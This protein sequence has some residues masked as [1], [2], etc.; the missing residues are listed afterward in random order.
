MN[1]LLDSTDPASTPPASFKEAL[2]GE[3][4]KFS[5]EEELAKGKWESDLYIK[6]L[7]T[8]MDQLTADYTRLDADYKA[9]ASLEEMI[10]K[11]GLPKTPASSDPPPANQSQPT[12]DQS[13]LKN[14]ISQSLQETREQEKQQTNFNMVKTKL[15]ERYGN[16]YQSKLTE[17]MQE[18]GLNATAVD[19]LAHTM[20]QVL[21]KTLG[22][23]E[24]TTE[25]FRAPVRSQQ[26]F[27]PTGE[28]KRNESF[29]NEMRKDNP[30]LYYDP[31]T[32]VQRHNDALAQGEA[33]FNVSMVN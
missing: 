23:G 18:L 19:N 30:K 2:V 9:R 17:Q 32:T 33:F 22:L 29:Y 7:E 16:D 28:K 4:K 10:D 3:G 24:Q 12:I 8:K 6:T 5:S 27:A 13:Q 20:P 21:I 14:L 25:P 26:N 15:I 11:I 31:K 1:T